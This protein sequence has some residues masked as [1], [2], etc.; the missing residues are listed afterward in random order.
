VEA[1]IMSFGHP[2]RIGTCALL[3][4]VFGTSLALADTQSELRALEK[5]REAA[6]QSQNFATLQTIYSPDFIAVTADG[7]FVTRDQLFMVFRN[8]SGSLDFD[9]DDI[10]IVASGNTAVLYGRMTAKM[11][12]GKTAFASRFSHVFVKKNGAW[13]CIAGQSTPLGK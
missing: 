10:R 9:T 4:L 2:G 3:A 13:V 12:D 5:R 1:F 7:Q 6:I 11:G 8:S